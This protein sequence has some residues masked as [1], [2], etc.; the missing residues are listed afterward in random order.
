METDYIRRAAAIDFYCSECWGRGNC[1]I[2]GDCNDVKPLREIPAADVVE[3]VRCR[4]CK[5]FI[6]NSKI[7]SICSG[8]CRKANWSKKWNDF[9]SDGERRAE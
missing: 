3:V 1:K 5:H 6:P 8:F 4:D 9:C 7:D 2:F